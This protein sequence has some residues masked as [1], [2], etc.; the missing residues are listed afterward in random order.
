MNS[1]SIVTEAE[2]L[3]RDLATELTRP[4]RNECLCCY[5]NRV[6][7][8]FPCDGT[9]RLTVHFRDTTAPRATGLRERLSRMG[10]CCCDCEVLMNAYQLVSPHRP[11]RPMADDVEP[12]SEPEPVDAEAPPCQGVRRGSVR[13]CANW[14]RVTR[15]SLW[16]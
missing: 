13:P 4:R 16:A 5:L 7:A 11:A 8:E 2:G 3:V 1:T 12:E 9:H 15:L 6:M 10:A 14:A